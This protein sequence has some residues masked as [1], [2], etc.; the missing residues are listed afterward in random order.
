MRIHVIGRSDALNKALKALA[1]EKN[2]DVSYTDEITSFSSMKRAIDRSVEFSAVILNIMDFGL[3]EDDVVEGLH[4]LTN[5]YNGVVIVYAPGASYSDPV[6]EACEDCGI[7]N[8]IRDI[9]A[10]RLN[11]NLEKMLSQKP[12]NQPQSTEPANLG[13]IPR[14]SDNM[15]ITHSEPY[16]DNNFRNTERQTTPSEANSDSKII[17]TKTIGVIG[18]I[19]RIGVTTQA[20]MILNTLKSQGKKACYIQYHDSMFLNNMENFFTGVEKNNTKGCLIYEGID[21]YKNP[22]LVLSKSYEY[23]IKDYGACQDSQIP[24]DFFNND[25]RFIVCGGTAEEVSRLTALRT[26]LFFDNDLHYVFSF[27]ADYEKEDINDLMGDKTN[28]VIFAPYTPDC[29]KLTEEAKSIYLPV[30]GFESEEKVKKTKF[31]FLKRK[32]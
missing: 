19:N 1:E 15:P 16:S 20:L 5:R 22:N 18:V 24:S 14:K 23:H 4:Y 10:S 8:I 2:Y 11:I 9:L 29:Y 17:I 12:N 25:I 21:F 26:Q 6:I 13:Y 31:G 3:G 28:D 27:I 32:G 30:L 7:E